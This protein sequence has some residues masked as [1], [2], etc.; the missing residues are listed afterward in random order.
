MGKDC[1]SANNR[2]FDLISGE[3]SVDL[4][5]GTVESTFK[6][7]G[8]DC[9]D[10]IAAIQSALKIDRVFKVEAKLMSSTVQV[11]YSPDLNENEIHRLINKSGV[12]VVDPN[13]NTKAISRQRVALV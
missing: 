6:V 1:C 8:M 4:P 7:N 3:S 11:W 9:A 10:E 13:K 5:A 12:K 2:V